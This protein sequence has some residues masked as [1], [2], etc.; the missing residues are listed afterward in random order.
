[1]RDKLVFYILIISIFFVLPARSQTIIWVSEWNQ[2]SNSIPFDQGWIDLLRAQGYDVIADTAGN[3][4]SLDSARINRLNSADLVIFS[5][6]SNSGNYI[7]GGEITQWNS[8]ETPLLLLSPY[9][10]RSRC[11]CQRRINKFKVK[12]KYLAV[13]GGA[14]CRSK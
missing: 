5:R 14:A 1:M 7:D 6:N 13:S 9:L 8:I 12:S 10:A 4:T 3:Y 11:Y 2:D